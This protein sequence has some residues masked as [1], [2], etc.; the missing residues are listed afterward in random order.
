MSDEQSQHQKDVYEA[1]RII[2]ALAIN[3][4]KFRSTPKSPALLE[5]EREGLDIAR[6]L[7][8]LETM[9]PEQAVLMTAQTMAGTIKSFADHEGKLD[10]L[11]VLEGAEERFFFGSADK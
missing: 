5:L 4:V 11:A 2:A 10:A 9:T 3:G 8:S 1:T 7:L 6:R